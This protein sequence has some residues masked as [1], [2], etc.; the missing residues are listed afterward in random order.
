MPWD[1]RSAEDVEEARSD[2]A[3][4]GGRRRPWT[5][6]RPAFALLVA[7]SWLVMVLTSLAGGFQL[8]GQTSAERDFAQGRVTSYAFLES[9]PG[10]GTGGWWQGS[11]D[12]LTD[13]SEPVEPQYSELVYTL[14]AGSPRIAVSEQVDPSPRVWSS[15]SEAETTWLQQQVVGSE[16]PSGVANLRLGTTAQVHAVLRV[17]LAGGMLALVLF[18][19]VPRH[20]NRWF[21]FWLI[22]LPAGLGVLAYA[23]W[24]IGGWRDHRAPA[25]ERRARGGYG[26]LVMFAG[27][28]LIAVAAQTLYGLLGATVI[29]L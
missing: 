17:V 1:A 22:G 25:P 5:V 4:S 12:G 7:G 11:L 2:R 20:G 28:V 21:W 8:V 16:I 24:E 18:G 9:R 3:S 19:P 26:F 10:T 29:P 23:V 14:A 27:G 6:L 15:W 13:A